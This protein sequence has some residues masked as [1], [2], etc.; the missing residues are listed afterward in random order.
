MSSTPGLSLAV[1]PHAN[2]G[3]V[4]ISRHALDKRSNYR[5]VVANHLVRQVTDFK[6]FDKDS[7]KR[8][9]DLFD[10][11]MYSVLAMI[12][13]GTEAQWTALKRVA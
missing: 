8:E 11:A 9:D 1:E 5:G 2:A 6:C 7:Y 12:G 13:D 10:A 4:K 3:R